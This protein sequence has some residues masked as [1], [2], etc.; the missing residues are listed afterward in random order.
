MFSTGVCV[1]TQSAETELSL[2]DANKILKSLV[3]S[4]RSSHQSRYWQLTRTSSLRYKPHTTHFPWTKCDWVERIQPHTEESYFP[5]DTHWRCAPLP[6]C[7][8]SDI[9]DAS[10]HF[11]NTVGLSGSGKW[12]AEYLCPVTLH[13]TLKWG[14]GSTLTSI[15]TNVLPALDV[16]TSLTE[17]KSVVLKRCQ[18]LGVWYSKGTQTSR[19]PSLFTSGSLICKIPWGSLT[20][21]CFH[22]PLHS[23]LLACTV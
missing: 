6:L 13:M 5:W 20:G 15:I 21:G 2:R 16:T 9:T 18:C 23:A 4:L 12:N 7:S 22:V 19:S 10:V 3:H 8:C 11:T 1:R 17:P 14:C